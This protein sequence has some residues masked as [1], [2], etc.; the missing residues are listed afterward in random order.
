MVRSLDHGGCERDAAKIAVGLDRTRFEPH[1]AVF[2]EGGF[3]TPEVLAAGVSVVHVPV[4]SFGNSST[5]RGARTLGKYIRKHGI[6][7]IHAFDVPTDLFAAPV[8]RWY[9]VPR[10][11][12]SQLSFRDMYPQRE[13]VALRFTD[14]LSD[15]VVV[16]SLAVGE[17]LQKEA[18]LSSEKIYLCY[19]GV[20]TAEFYPG[21]AKRPDAFQNAS[22]VIGSVCVMRSEKRMDWVLRSF[23]EI[24]K[25]DPQARLLL[26]GSGPEVFPLTSL[27]DNLGLTD[28][29][30]FI[31][32]QPD[33]AQWMRTLDIYI[34]SSSSESFPN[35]LLE[36]MACGCCVIGSSVGGIPE[37]VTHGCDGL[38]FNSKDPEDLTQKLRL[39]VTDASLRAEL[40][41]QAVITAHQKF[42]MKVTLERTESLYT[43]L[44][45]GRNGRKEASA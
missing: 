9:R 14:R 13:R 10:V 3:R 32:G 18:G 2:H 5:I 43:K 6:Q 44:L 37:L 26:V 8:A 15:T 38:V 17:S 12:T 24:I 33:V 7:L 11:V 42:S 36:A 25:I 45:S 19:N 23:A 1:V 30:M 16:N 22:V 41:R 28:A 39:A 29:C 35:G 34:N 21:P 31:P 40:R 20:N 27:R 4:T